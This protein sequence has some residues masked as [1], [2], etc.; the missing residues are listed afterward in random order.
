MF[1]NCR[2]RFLGQRRADPALGVAE[3]DERPQQAWGIGQV[4][5]IGDDLARNPVG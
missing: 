1:G 4:G 2:E 5:N 3:P